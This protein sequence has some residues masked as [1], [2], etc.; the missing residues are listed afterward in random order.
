VDHDDRKRRANIRKVGVIGEVLVEIMAVEPGEGFR[1]PIAL[2]GPFPSG[3]PAIF[4]DQMARFGHPCGLVGCVGDD[5]FGR[6]NIDRLR[7]DGVD[8]S[9]IRIHERAVTGSAFVRYRPDGSRDFVFNIRD[10]AA[11]QTILTNEGRQMIAGC[12]HLHVMGSTLCAPGVAEAVEDALIMIKG[13]GG[14]VS[15]DP[16]IRKEMLSVPGLKERLGRVLAVTDVFLPSGEEL[17]LL[18]EAKDELAA[19]CE[20]L[21]RGVKVVVVKKGAEGAVWYDD[22][23]ILAARAFDVTQVDPTGAG[24]CFSAVLVACWLEGSDP[25]QALRLANAAGARTV[26]VKGPMEG[27]AFRADLEAWMA[28]QCSAPCLNA[29]NP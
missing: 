7:A 21:N 1:A 19:A 3:A 25:T 17:F 14:S 28:M 18:T 13:M 20:I 26:M 27:A 12:G 23:R 24:D 11:G 15:F 29:R 8:V 5:D 22:E 2:V 6:L 16:N 9:A 4:V 10:S